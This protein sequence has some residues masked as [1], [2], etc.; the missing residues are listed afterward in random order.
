MP[1]KDQFFSGEVIY[2]NK[3]FGF[4]DCEE[5][6]DNIFFHKSALN[7]SASNVF[8]FD[9]LSFRVQKVTHGKHKGSYRAI[10]VHLL[11]KGSVFEHERYVGVV[12]RLK[13]RSG[14]IDYPTKEGEEILL[15]RTRLIFDD[16]IS[17]GDLVVFNPVVN[18]KNRDQLFAFFAYPIAFESDVQFLMKQYQ[19]QRL[20]QLRQFIL[21]QFSKEE[22]WTQIEIELIEMGEVDSSEQYLRLKKLLKGLSGLVAPFSLLKKYVSTP[23]LVLLLTEKLIDTYEFD[24]VYDHFLNVRYKVK[25]NLFACVSKETEKLKLLEAWL[26][27][28]SDRDAF[29]N[30]PTEVNSFIRCFGRLDKQTA[31][32]FRDRVQAI[33]LEKLSP[34]DN[35][36]RWIKGELHDELSTDYVLSNTN[37]CDELK[38]KE[39][40]S[41]RSRLKEGI[42]LRYEQE[43]SKNKLHNPQSEQFLRLAKMLLN[44]QKYF[45]PSSAVIDDY[46]GGF[47]TEIQLYFWCLG[48]EVDQFEDLIKVSFVQLDAYFQLRCLLRMK[49]K[50]VDQAFIS[51]CKAKA[52]INQTSLQDLF[53]SREWSEE[54]LYAVDIEQN[55]AVQINTLSFIQDVIDCDERF[56][57]RALLEQLYYSTDDILLKARIWLFTEN[58]K[59]YDYIRFS[60]IFKK[61]GRN[62]QK[63]FK[64]LG[65]AIGKQDVE[66]REVEGVKPCYHFKDQGDGRFLYEASLLNIF[67]ENNLLR[68]RKHDGSYTTQFPYNGCSLGLNRVPAQHELA[69]QVINIK[70][71]DGQIKKVEGLDQ[72]LEAIEVASIS[73]SLDQI[74]IHSKAS[75]NGESSL[76]Y[77]E[78]WDLRK[79]VVGY[80]NKLNSRND[81]PEPVYVSEAESERFMEPSHQNRKD[82]KSGLFAIKLSQG[83]AIVWENIDSSDNKATKVFKCEDQ[84]LEEYIERIKY[85]IANYTN[86]RSTLNRSHSEGPL[87]TF[88]GF[89]GYVG[90]V[91]KFRGRSNAFELWR[92]KLEA[93]FLQPIPAYSDMSIDEIEEL[94]ADMISVKLPASSSRKQGFS[95]DSQLLK[96][97][98]I[99]GESGVDSATKG[100]G[101]KK[102]E[103]KKISQALS[104]LNNI[105]EGFFNS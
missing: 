30:R 46:F 29:A 96:T 67:F 23:F 45:A 80:L 63:K 105:L 89:H 54:I 4:I 82:H 33:A 52:S 34:A 15:F 59:Y 50:Q 97:K 92:E 66:V 26:K 100:S 3:S 86:L 58:E 16:N 55:K 94:Y 60:W 13:V 56:D 75:L 39:L 51:S 21:D 5:L 36:K 65:D 38:V 47:S 25:E 37:L 28:L 31:K 11:K 72:I 83:F 6:D 1:D 84:Y 27:G 98:S 90:T 32:E 53:L 104:D 103:Y 62:E 93:S 88:S 70:V 19:L 61:L 73:N 74:S 95:L 40:C 64:R 24:L 68:L 14:Y 71:A 42:L 44:Y 35:I 10:D 20:P 91:E 43:L 41:H 9:T 87:A 79:V 85:A 99:I 49:E 102:E 22:V 69:K 101:K 57:W 2:W 18:E 77:V 17:N 48:Y 78:D 12:E 76:A 7:F 81:A 8:L